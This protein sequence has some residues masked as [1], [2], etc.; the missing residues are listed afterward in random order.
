MV[1]PFT[2]EL[3]AAIARLWSANHKTE[4]CAL[5][6]KEFRD[7]T[8]VCQKLVARTPYEVKADFDASQLRLEI[9]NLFRTVGA[10]WF[11]GIT[12]T[13]ETA[14]SMLAKAYDEDKHSVVQLVPLDIADDLPC[15][16]FGPFEVRNI[17]AAEFSEVVQR[18][19]LGRFGPLWTPDVSKLG[20]FTWFIY[21]SVQLRYPPTRS[22]TFLDGI[23]L[24]EVGRVRHGK[25][26][27]EPDLELG[28]FVLILPP[29][30]DA[31]VHDFWTWQPFKMPWV[32]KLSSDPLKDPPRAPDPTSLTWEFRIDPNTEEEYEV[33]MQNT[34]EPKIDLHL[35]EL[36][37]LWTKAEAVLGRARVG[38]GCFNP[39]IEHYF[40][41]AFE[42]EDLD[43]L[44][45]HVA[46]VDAAI[47]DG[48]KKRL[49]KRVQRLVQDKKLTDIFADLYD[50][51]SEY[52]HGR[53]IDD[54]NLWQK[55]L[56]DARR[57][58][59]QIVV[60]VLDLAYANPA[61]NR[62]VLLKE[63]AK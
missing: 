22:A 52:I 20:Q 48:D 42:D 3:Q 63:L 12:P 27:F 5:T 31:T 40:L 45:W 26:R 10:P 41:R 11:G 1:G 55:N 62:K 21:R 37:Q 32:Y 60:G 61:W 8:A 49:V 57:V 33:P 13:S 44:L 30:E 24:D 18:A 6:S 29:W 38:N 43:Q 58:A 36:P 39:L 53:Q 46:T 16:S 56:R 15:C 50:L 17:S 34:L 47:G 59:R 19:R 14:I 28:M 23:Q 35:D 4:E 25:R 2:S 9:R 54:S 7:L 51:R